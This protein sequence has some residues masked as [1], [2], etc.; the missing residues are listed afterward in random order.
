MTPRTLDGLAY[1]GSGRN[2]KTWWDFEDF[3][4]GSYAA[5]TGIWTTGLFGA[6]S[7]ISSL[8]ASA[9]R[10]GIAYYQTGSTTTG[11]ATQYA[12]GPNGDGILFGAGVYTFEADVNVIDLSTAGEEYVLQIGFGDTSGADFVD[13]AYFRYDRLAAGANWRCKT[14][15]N[16][17]RTDTD[18]GVAVAAGPWVKLKVVVNAAASEVYFYINGALVATNTTNIP[19]GAGRGTGA[20]MQ[21]LKSAGTTLRGFLVDWVWLHVDFNVA[22]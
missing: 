2:T 20:L 11:R 5:Y 3:D 4:E 19:S 17:A 13:G 21:I 7:M 10:K 12:L 18:S 15:S 6:G 9:D 14:A 8:A 1:S 22:R 16:S